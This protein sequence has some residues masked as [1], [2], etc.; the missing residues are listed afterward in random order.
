VVT[1][2]LGIDIGGTT[3]K[4][5][6]VTLDGSIIESSTVET[7]TTAGGLTDAVLS[8][9]QCLRDA[10]T[11]AAGLASPGIVHDDVVQFAANLPW[12][13]EPIR[14]RVGSALGLPV[15]LS[16]D[17][18][19]AALAEARHAGHADMLFVG[20]G[21]GVAGVHVRGGIA[22]RGATGQAG[23]IGHAPVRPD[24]EACACGQRG[25]LEVYA[26]AAAIARRYAARTGRPATADR[27]AAAVGADPDAAAVWGEAVEALAL[28]L[29]TDVLVSDPG[30]IVLGGGLAA[31][32]ET[33]LAPLR[34]ALA[35]R[36]SFRTPPP[37]RVALLGPMA[38]VLGAAQLAARLIPPGS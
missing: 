15:V 9:A 29:A 37:V 31:A 1:N 2:V 12:R 8:L 25:C 11:A 10:D 32:G 38:G 34:I 23:E 21:T 28:A 16:P 27:I 6:R 36:L 5:A 26:S 35:A 4:G 13:E 18:V 14:A 22:H 30:V 19:A 20:I 3:V 33:L 17:R 7:P 24:G